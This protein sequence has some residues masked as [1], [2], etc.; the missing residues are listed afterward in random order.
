MEKGG[1]LFA[2]LAN[3]AITAAHAVFPTPIFG[4]DLG[5]DLSALFFILAA[6]LFNR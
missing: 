1:G 4:Q 2:A 5:P 3:R 6:K